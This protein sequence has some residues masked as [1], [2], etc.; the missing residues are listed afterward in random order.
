MAMA[1]HAAQHG[2]HIG[3]LRPRLPIDLV[4]E[5]AGETPVA[6]PMECNAA[7]A[8][9]L[10]DTDYTSLTSLFPAQDA[11]RGFAWALATGKLIQNLRHELAASGLTIGRVVSGH[12]D[13]LEEAER[14]VDMAR[15]EMRYLDLL[16][17]ANRKDPAESRILQSESPRVP[18]GTEC[19]ILACA[20]D[21]DPIALQA[22]GHL[23]ANLPVQVLV[24]APEAM[25]DRF[26][27]WGRPIA[28]RWQ[29]A[30]IDIPEP[31]R[32]IRLAGTPAEQARMLAEVLDE[33]GYGPADTGVGVPDTDVLP[34]LTA[35]L[36]RQAVEPYDP[37]GVP[38]AHHPLY[39]LVEAYRGL[40]DNG[41]YESLAAFL[42]H[43]DILASLN[44]GA[45]VSPHTVLADL[46]E[47][48]NAHLPV[49]L[50][51]VR[52]H[53]KSDTAYGSLAAAVR[54]VDDAWFSTRGN[55]PTADMRSFLESVFAHRRLSAEES[56]DGDFVTVAQLVS[57]VLGD[58]QDCC[59]TSFAFNDSDA[60][61]LIAEQLRSQRYEVP[62]HGAEVDLEGWLELHWND[63]SCM[64]VTGMNEGRVPES[65]AADAFL[66]NSLRKRLGLRCD[67]DRFAR[68][69]YLMQAMVESRRSGGR[70]C[71]ISGKTGSSGDPLKPSRL[72]F[73]CNDTELPSR[74][75]RLFGPPDSHLVN[76][77]ASTSF[78]LRPSPPADLTPVRHDLTRLAVTGFRDYLSC[79]FRFY[80]KRVLRMKPL[81]DLKREMDA[82]DFGSLLHEVLSRMAQDGSLRNTTSVSALTAFLHDEAGK[83]MA[84]QYGSSL[85]L[86]LQMQLNAARERLAAVA[87]IQTA[88]V[89][90]GWEI[91][92]VEHPV[93]TS[94]AGL[95]VHGQIDRVDRNS[96][97]GEYRVLDYKTSD[98]GDAPETEHLRTPRDDT[99]DYAIVNVNGKDRA[100][101]DLQLPLYAFLLGQEKSEMANAV[102][103]Y[104]NIPG[105]V[106]ETAVKEWGTFTTGLLEAAELCAA[107][108][109]RDIAARRFWPPAQRVDHDDFEAL[110]AVDLESAIDFESFRA[111]LEG[112]Q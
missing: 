18:P 48:Q 98:R 20:P 93:E 99:P 1:T 15:L 89:E 49:D 5:A 10:L 14:W 29:Q 35:E 11:V 22:L 71:F 47:F 54:H 112:N 16:G 58:Y 107:G 41:S 32:N 52:S 73:S 2:A 62:R 39:A 108:I 31:E 59:A 97:T 103:G 91:V 67:D 6:T 33:D 68:D 76:Y 28:T 34:F 81:D 70:V 105:T 102:P 92:L 26:D 79:P 85:P 55:G 8:R 23:A 83:W 57:D 77:P 51:D 3:H 78:L 96:K 94:I 87:R 74:A 56:A 27:D 38:V 50:R 36:R 63:A 44:A 109:A 21:P 86:N 12:P 7:W 88:E 104:F 30:A 100:W 80:L 110:F 72:L 66:P 25:A 60:R 17:A 42:R 111:Y 61:T 24:H 64:V 40:L 53:L 101:K 37:N 82:M 46:D 4:R 90:K 84:R 69:L 13:E 75:R 43:P 106:D 45:A 19:V 65:I 95:T 9:L